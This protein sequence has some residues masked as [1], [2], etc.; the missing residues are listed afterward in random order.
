MTAVTKL[1]AIRKK[2]IISAALR[3]IRLVFRM[4]L[5]LLI[6]GITATPVS[7]PDSPRASFGKTKSERPRITKTLRVTGYRRC[8]DRRP[9]VCQQ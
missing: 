8:E 3:S 5:G 4:R 7:K 6:S 1:L 2:L 9:P